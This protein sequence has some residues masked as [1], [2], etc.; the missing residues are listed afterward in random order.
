MIEVGARQGDGLQ[1]A[2]Q[3]YVARAVGQFGEA[4][5][6]RLKQV[7]LPAVPLIDSRMQAGA[8]LGAFDDDDL[9]L[10]TIDWGRCLQLSFAA[11]RWPRP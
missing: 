4:A 5:V 7:D 1:L 9:F 3:L 10:G 11:A 6:E 2:H 8:T